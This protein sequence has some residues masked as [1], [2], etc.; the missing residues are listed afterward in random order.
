MSGNRCSHPP[1]T[2]LLIHIVLPVMG[3][4]NTNWA[5]SGAGYEETDLFNVITEAVL[6]AMD[7]FKDK[8]LA[9]M[10]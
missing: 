5:F 6:P 1:T 2:S 10:L 8:E 4:A 9:S 3:I 7:D